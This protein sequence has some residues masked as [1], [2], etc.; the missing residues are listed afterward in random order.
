MSTALQ[1]KDLIAEGDGEALTPEKL[2]EMPDGTRYELVNGKLKEHAMGAES[3]LVAANVISLLKQHARPRKLGKVFASDC[4]YQ[5]FPHNPK[6]VRKPD[7]SFIARGR[8]PDDKAPKG[9]ITIAPDLGL[10]IVS[11]NDTAE[12]IEA[13]RIDFMRAGTRLFWVLYPESR[14]VHVFH[15]DGSSVVLT[16]NDELHGEDVLPEFTCKVAE[17]FEDA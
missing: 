13:R 5:A 16:E 9:H 7:G 1:E 6:Q 11:P 14:T 15:Q 17:L 8:L 10:E 2:L 4:G 12:D 3:S